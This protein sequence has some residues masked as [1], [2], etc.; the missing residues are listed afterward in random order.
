MRAD[1]NI[2]RAFGHAFEGGG[3]GFAAVETRQAGDFHRKVGKAVGKI[4][5]VL[6]DQQ[7][8]GRE[9][10]HLF[11]AHY[12]DKGGAQ[13]NFGFAE[14][15]I[16]AHQSIHRF[17]LGEVFQ[18]RADGGGLVFGFFVAEAVGKGLVILLVKGEFEAFLRCALG[19]EVE[20]LG[21]GVARFFS[22]FALGFRPY[23][24]AEFVQMHVFMRLAGVA[25]D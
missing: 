24:A 5:R 12:G 2:H 1:D 14:A 21:G 19:V 8:G 10:S 17:A 13:G 7:R 16:A 9:H 4:L 18:H 15:D 22:G 6:L 23:A 25:A 3:G 20:Q 11:A